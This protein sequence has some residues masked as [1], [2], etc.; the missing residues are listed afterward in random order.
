MEKETIMFKHNSFFEVFSI[1]HEIAG[2]QLQYINV[3]Q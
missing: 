2:D 3:T 1:L